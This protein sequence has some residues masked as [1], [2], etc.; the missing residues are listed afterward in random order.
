[1]DIQRIEWAKKTGLKGIAV[2]LDWQRD[3]NDIGKYTRD[4]LRLGK[5]DWKKYM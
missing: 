3:K 4:S 1:M 2:N 5:G